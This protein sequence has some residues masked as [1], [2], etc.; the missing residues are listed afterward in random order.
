[1]YLVDTNVVSTGA[2]SRSL[3]SASLIQWMDANSARLY[4]SVITLTEVDD[5]IAKARRE[6]ATRKADLLAEWFELLLH[7]YGDRILPYDIAVAR[8]AGRL[9]DR[10][11]GMGLAPGLADLT[12]AATAQV[13]KLT[14]LTRN[15]KHFSPLGVAAHD[16]FSS[17]PN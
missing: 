8:I 6:G 15:L 9:S 14:V 2:P 12:I 16:P 4:L 1:M 10:A 5:G 11:R 7:L 3:S 13:H 17:L